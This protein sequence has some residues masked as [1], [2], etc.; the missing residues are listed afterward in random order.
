[1]TNR[2]SFERKVLKIG[3][4]GPLPPPYGGM[5][6]QLNQLNLLLKRED[7][8]VSVVQ[9]NAPY[10]KKLIGKIRGLRA[11]FRLFPYLYNI[12]ALA[13][14]VDVIHVLANSGWSWQLFSAPVLWI[15]NFKKTPVIINYR[16]GEA[17]QYFK[18]SI[19]LIRPSMKLASQIIVPSGY[20]EKVFNDFGF[21]VKVIPN[22]I[23][24]KRFKPKKNNSGFHLIITRNLEAIYGI[25]TAIKSIAIVKK[26]IPEIQLTIAG[27]GEQ[28]EYLQKRVA[29]LEFAE[30]IFFVGKLKPDDVAKLYQSADIMLNPTTVDNMPNSILE[31]MACGVPIISTNVGGVPYMVEDN[32]TALLVEVGNSEMMADKIIELFNDKDQYQTLASNGLK[33]VQQ[34]SWTNIKG[35]WL[36]LYES[37]GGLTK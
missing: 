21:N 22:I 6:N 3:L 7:I 10:P 4:V 12:W 19:K 2:Y 25:E 27:S 29:D 8:D 1:M 28:K 18:Q 24:L 15:C 32:K 23:D 36:A 20:L 30:N 34:Y 35:Q 16:G 37:L 17:R 14:R 31:A 26:I 5:A 9:T 33:E 13:C 11:I